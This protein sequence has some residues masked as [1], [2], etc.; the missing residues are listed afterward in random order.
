[1]DTFTTIR[2]LVAE[3]L[4]LPEEPLLHEQSLSDAGIDSL[5]AIELVFSIE[6]RF[7]IQ[8]PPDELNTVRS[9][10]D[11]AAVADRQLSRKVHRH[12]E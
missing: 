7:A 5:A 9:L 6:S 3:S 2:R 11:L 10:R 1:M 12:D 4:H 8:I